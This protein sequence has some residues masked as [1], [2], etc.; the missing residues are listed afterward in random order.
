[1]PN[2][3]AIIG[4]GAQIHFYMK[5]KTPT[6]YRVGFLRR[7][8]EL[9]D[10]YVDH[11]KPWARALWHEWLNVSPGIHIVD[12]GCGTGHFTRFLA[13]GLKGQGHVIGIDSREVSLKTAQRETER[14]G[15]AKIVEYRRGDA[16]NLPLQGSFADLVA[17]RTLLMHLKQPLKAIQEMCR[18]T[19]LGGL[20]GAVETDYRMR[21]YY[22]PRGKD[23]DRL[24]RKISEAWIKGLAK[25]DGK[26]YTI[27]SK[28]PTL[29]ARAGLVEIKA[30][31]DADPWL[32]CDPRRPLKDK[33]FDVRMSLEGLRHFEEDRKYLKAGGLSRSE[34]ETY[35]KRAIEQY[36]KFIKQPGKLN[37]DTTFYGACWFIVTGRK[38]SVRAA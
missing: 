1:M 31:L 7:G 27:G 32:N 6:V 9:Y 34:I 13:R 5:P 10:R 8:R 37:N 29:F 25:L 11:V 26:D 19:K 30:N 28:L 3:K 18:I 17:C 36:R 23:L 14:E 21:C 33:L 38:S 4:I 22:N 15:L 35:R 12:V 16:L 2:S 20:V 24:G